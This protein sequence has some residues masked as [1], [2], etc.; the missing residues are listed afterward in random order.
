MKLDQVEIVEGRTGSGEATVTYNRK[1]VKISRSRSE[2]SDGYETDFN[3][4][5][6]FW[7]TTNQSAEYIDYKLKIGL[8]KAELAD[9]KTKLIRI[10]AKF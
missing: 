8:N 4:D 9:F 2:Y 7:D 10:F 6:E 3:G 5:Y 1:T